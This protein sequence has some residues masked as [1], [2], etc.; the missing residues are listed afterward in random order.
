MRSP[1]NNGPVQLVLE[2]VACAV[3]A[4]A[5]LTFVPRVRAETATACVSMLGARCMSS[6]YPTGE[7]AMK[8]GGYGCS[9]CWEDASD[10]CDGGYGGG[11]Q[12]GFSSKKPGAD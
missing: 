8:C 9:T 5:A 12:S 7:L 3:I 4:A 6:T 1:R 2:A 11:S 10:S